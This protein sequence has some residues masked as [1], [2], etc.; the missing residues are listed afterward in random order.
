MLGEV[1]ALVG[2]LYG[3]YGMA[4]GNSTS[5]P[6]DRLFYA[7]GANSMRGWAPRMLG[8]GAVPEPEDAVFPTQLGDMKLEANLELR[9][10]IWGMFHG[11]TFVDVGNIW[12]ADR[13]S[14]PS[15]AAV[16]IS[17]VSTGN[18]ASMP[19]S[20]CAWTSNL[21][22]CVWTGAYRSTTPMHLPDNGGSTI[23]SGR[24]RRLISE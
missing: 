10:P 8:P 16:S 4:Y 19:V 9:F 11:A 18:W 24:I 14:A 5:I 3:G 7:G 6:F 21:P 15:P 1:T 12:F 2:R 20:V 17:T 13:H 22:Y 23:S